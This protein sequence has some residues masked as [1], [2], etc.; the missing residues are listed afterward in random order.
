VGN[1]NELAP[2]AR[3]E[4]H[5]GLWAIV[6]APLL[7]GADLRNLQQVALDV[8]RNDEVIAV[9]QDGLG[10]AGDLICEHGPVQ[11]RTPGLRAH[12]LG[13]E[14]QCPAALCCRALPP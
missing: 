3:A 8:L 11:V 14:W 12:Y 5:F 1:S 4:A 6:K 9:N 10:V 2:Q 13:P 7:L